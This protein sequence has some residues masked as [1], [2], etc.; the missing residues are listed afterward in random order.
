[1]AN[2]YNIDDILMEEEFVPVV[3]HKAV[4]GVTIDPSSE[5]NSVE[6]GAKVELPF[7]LAQELHLRQALSINVPACFNQKTKLEIQADAACV[8]LNSRCPY[9]YEFGCKIEPLVGDRTIA[10][11]LSTSFKIRYKE[12]LT[13]AYTMAYAT[14]SKFMSLLTREEK[15]LYEAAQSSM[16][17]F[18]KWRKGGPRFQRASIL[19]RKRKPTD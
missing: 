10:I 18:K 8:D 2:Y 12:I 15:N 7:W 3:F 14:A 4:N 13:K 9:F 6:Q 1:M 5:T 19:G 16:V 11:L 17:A